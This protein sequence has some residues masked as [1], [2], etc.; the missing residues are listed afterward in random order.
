VFW[1]ALFVF[2]LNA[3]ARAF[4]VL[5]HRPGLAQRLSFAMYFAWFLVMAFHLLS[6]V[7]RANTM[8]IGQ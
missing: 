3:F 7:P 1:T 4:P 2:A 5:E 8:E 6:A